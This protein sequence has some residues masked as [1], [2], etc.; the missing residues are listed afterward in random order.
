MHSRQCPYFAINRSDIFFVPI[1]DPF[2][3]IDGAMTEEIFDDIEY[4]HLHFGRSEIRLRF[5]S[6]FLFTD[7]HHLFFVCG[8]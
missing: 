2:S 1:I 5:I 6:E 7:F 4:S 3:R 8:A